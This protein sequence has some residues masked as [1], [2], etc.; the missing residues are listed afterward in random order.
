MCSFVQ[1]YR[2]FPG[3]LQTVSAGSPVLTWSHYVE[4]MRVVD[5]DARAWYYRQFIEES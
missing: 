3:I 5:D 1:F 2:M 4:L